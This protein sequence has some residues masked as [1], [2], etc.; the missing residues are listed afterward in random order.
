[1]LFFPVNTHP[2]SSSVGKALCS[3]CYERQSFH[4]KTFS[5][6]ITWS[7]YKFTEVWL[8]P[9]STSFPLAAYWIPQE[10]ISADM[11]LFLPLFSF[12]GSRDLVG[13]CIIFKNICQFFYF[14]HPQLTSYKSKSKVSKFC[15]WGPRNVMSG[16]WAACKENERVSA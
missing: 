3:S 6:S 7:F 15:F 14:L 13:F 10:R 11:F 1:M 8:A 2:L 5:L 4:V 12:Q 9:T 16:A